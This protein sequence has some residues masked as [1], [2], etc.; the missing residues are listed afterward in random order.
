MDSTFLRM[1]LLALG[2]LVLVGLYFWDT[3]H[4]HKRPL[5]AKQR[6]TPQLGDL[7][8]EA[9]TAKDS[10]WRYADQDPENLDAELAQ[11]TQK[12]HEE[13]SES[14]TPEPMRLADSEADQQDLFG[15]SA[16]EESPVDVPTKIVQINL[17]ASQG[18]R[19][20]GSAILAATKEVG[21][22]AGEMQ[23]FHRFTTDGRNKTQFSMASLVEPG[24]FPF[25][26][27]EEFSTPGLTLFCQLPGPGDSLA[28]FSDML[29]TAQRLLA[30][31]G[32]ELQDDTHSAL[33]KQTV[34]HIRSQILEHRRQVQLARSRR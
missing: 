16:P 21:L 20:S 4:R 25:K 23:I 1:I 19:Y 24:V 17:I 14:I 26:A 5:Q 9:E 28:I 7:N 10:D 15:F 6:A 11:L 13:A 18:K 34:E 32:G 3:K 8:P 30:I 12:V 2:I 33:T 29:Y 22:K 31:L 27:M